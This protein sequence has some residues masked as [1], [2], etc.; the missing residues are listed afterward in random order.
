MLEQLERA[1]LFLLPVDQDRRWYRYHALFADLLRQRLLP[2]TAPPGTSGTSDA[3]GTGHRPGE[4]VS[5]TE[6]HRRASSWYEAEGLALEAFTH[7]VAAADLDRAARL[8]EGQGMP[9]HFRG[10]VTPVLDWLASLPTPEL[11]ARPALWVMFASASLISGNLEGVEEKLQAAETALAGA[12]ANNR[13]RDLLGR[14]AELRATLALTRHQVETMLTESRRALE[15]LD[16]DNLAF[17]TAT[18]WKLGFAHEL[19]GDRAAASQAY[20]EVITMSRTSGNTIFTVLATTSLG[21]I[22]LAEN[23]LS[24]AAE[25]YQRGLDLIGE[26]ALPF[27][28]EA[29]L[30]LARIY[31]EWN[32]LETA[33]EHAEQSLHLARRIENTDR[34]VATAVVLAR[35]RLAQGNEAD[36]AALVAEASHSAH[37]HHL[38]YRQPEVAAIYVLVLIRQGH[39]AAAARQA[40]AI[41]LPLSQARV[42]LAEGQARRRPRR[43]GSLEGAGGSSGMDR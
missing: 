24:Q 34:T 25:T 40:E 6:L 4:E 33:L 16:P 41:D 1:N 21:N 19:Q 12:D 43:P 11:D 17:R 20:A 9:L 37:Q 36:A 42:R 3:T 18:V 35:L 26:A 2:H 23:Q 14:V 5:V 30:G 28:C 27:A 38:V 7:A 31:Y 39:L 13:D 15:N 29:R 32:D 8:V 22:Q 10:A